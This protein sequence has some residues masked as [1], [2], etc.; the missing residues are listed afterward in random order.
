MHS[1]DFSEN[2]LDVP[3]ETLQML[4][5]V[6]GQGNGCGRRPPRQHVGPFF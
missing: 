5:E 4:Q 6:G 2:G 3:D 1:G